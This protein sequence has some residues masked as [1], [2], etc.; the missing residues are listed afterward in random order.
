MPNRL[1]TYFAATLLILVSGVNT[2]SATEEFVA[3]FPSWSNVQRDYGAVGDGK[4][5]DTEA[6]QRALDDLRFRKRGCVLFFPSGTYR[7]TKTVKTVRKAHTEG[8]G[9]SITGENPATTV[10]RW[11]GDKGGMMLQYDAWYSTIRR[12]TLDGAGKAGVCLAYG[13]AVVPPRGTLRL[14]TKRRTWFSRTP[15]SV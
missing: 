3:P 7:I 4:A 12:L 5:D 11:D 15:T 1:T 8:M 6:I 2:V 13:D 9:I 10:I 14:T